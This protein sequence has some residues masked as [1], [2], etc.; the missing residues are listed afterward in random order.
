VPPLSVCAR[1]ASSLSSFVLRFVIVLK[2]GGAF[3]L[4]DERV[5]RAVRPLRRA[6]MAQARVRFG[7]E[8]FQKCG[9]EPRFPDTCLAL[10][11]HDL[12]FA[13][14]CPVPAPNK[15]SI[16]DERRGPRRSPTGVA[17]APRSGCRSFTLSA[18]D[19]REWPVPNPKQ[20]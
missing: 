3:R 11:Q 15:Q 2:A 9:R 13:R 7:G 18:G 14:L 20:Q 5:E 6:A 1:T 12:A 10:E 8:A 19:N 17:S 16:W 4:T